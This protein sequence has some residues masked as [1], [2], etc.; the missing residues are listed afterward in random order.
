MESF[1]LT[2]A[3]TSRAIVSGLGSAVVVNVFAC[4][5]RDHLWTPRLTA[6]QI[7]GPY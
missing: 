7:S 4:L 5:S 3:H 1:N 2:A 6:S